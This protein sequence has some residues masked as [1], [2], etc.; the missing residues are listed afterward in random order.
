MLPLAVAKIPGGYFWAALVGFWAMAALGWLNPRLWAIWLV[1]AVG[2]GVSLYL[3]TL[4]GDTTWRLFG[5]LRDIHSLGD[6]I[7][8]VQ[9][10][11]AILLAIAWIALLRRNSVAG[12]V[13]GR[14][15][16]F[17]PG[18]PSAL[19]TAGIALVA[20]MLPSLLIVLPSGNVGHFTALQSVLALPFL[21][22]C[23]A[24]TLQRGIVPPQGPGRIGG[25]GR[26]FRLL[27]PIQGCALERAQGALAQQ[28]LIRTGDVSF[29]G[30]QGHRVFRADARRFLKAGGL[31]QIREGVIA[32]GP[33]RALQ[34]QLRA[35]R[36]EFGNQAAVYAPQP[37][38]G[39]PGSALWDLTTDCAGKSLFTMATA[40]LPML[41]GY[42]PCTPK[43]IYNGYTPPAQ[44]IRFGR[45][46]GMPSCH[47]SG[48]HRDPDRG[49]RRRAGPEPAAQLPRDRLI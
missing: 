48:I 4:P 23:G 39:Q 26:R 1:L 22:L 42:P 12:G 47:R 41:Y 38:E 28:A 25:A 15:S 8:M 9:D 10:Y 46:R 35:F 11:G 2:L 19:P 33:A 18:L 32:D 14:G 17:G 16:F 36:A 45:W 3:L 13:L 44:L 20:A 31:A 24:V 7:A 49:I 43:F 34:A 29:Y 40:G 5:R 27:Q 21:I 37:V 6:A 30:E